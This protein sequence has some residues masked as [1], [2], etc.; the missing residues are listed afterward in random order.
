MAKKKVAKK[1]VSKKKVAKK[2]VAKKKIVK[3]KVAKKK[4]A[5]K[6]V[7]KKKVAKKKVAKKK[8][9]KKKVAKKKV[10]KKKVAKKKVAKKKVAKK[11]VAKKKV[12]KKKAVKKTAK[13]SMLG[14]VL[15]KVSK[16][17]D[18]IM[19][20][21]TAPAKAKAPVKKEAKPPV[22]VKE[23]KEPLNIQDKMATQARIAE[24]L[25]QVAKDKNTGKVSIT[26][27]EGRVLCRSINCDQ[28]AVVD[29]Y[30]RYHYLLH[31]KKIQLRRKILS[32]GKLEK[33][34][35]DLTARYPD[36][37]LDI[38]A[39]D[40][41]SEKDFQQTCLELGITGSENEVDP[42]ENDNSDNDPDF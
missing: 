39:K 21:A 20:K 16:T 9:A 14:K 22:S 18:K 10:T 41:A 29:G 7:A 37:F 35:Q 1:K 27:A 32:E 15:K 6:K 19:K 28:A 40:L 24:A 25:A 38:L 3:K 33:Y 17:A 13:G 8:V 4:V 26:D 42:D 31:W 36:K 11:K 2:K 12:A 34:V 30:C 23:T 5:K